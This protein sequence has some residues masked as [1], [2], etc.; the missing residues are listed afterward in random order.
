MTSERSVAWLRMAAVSTISTMKVERPRAQVVG[1]ADAREQA[2]DDADVRRARRHERAHLR[3]HGNQARSG[4]RRSDLPAMFGPVTSQ[5]RASVTSSKPV[6]MLGAAAATSTQSFSMNA[7]A[8][9]ALS[10][11]STTG[12]RAAADLEGDAVVE[13]GS[14]VALLG[15]DLGEACLAVEFGQRCRQLA[16]AARARGRSRWRSIRRTFPLQRDGERALG[17]C[18]DAALGLDQLLRW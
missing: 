2:I 4:A 7:P 1:G 10:A 8:L 5:I 16:R 11:C 17:G 18:D 12:W 6:G 13:P 15:G 9:A 3:Q 14:R